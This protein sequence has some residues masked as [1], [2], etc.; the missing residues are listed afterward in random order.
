MATISR[1]TATFAWLTAAVVVLAAAQRPTPA[2]SGVV[3]DIAGRPI[4]AIEIQV[5]TPTGATLKIL[6]AADGSYEI[7]IKTPGQYDI[8]MERA[9]FKNQRA[10]RFVDG[11]SRVQHDMLLSIGSISQ[12]LTITGNKPAGDSAPA[13][14]IPPP[15]PLTRDP[16]PLSPKPCEFTAGGSDIVEPRKVADVRPIYPLDLL[17]DGVS[18]TVVLKGLVTKQGT[19]ADIKVLQEAHEKLAAAASA[20]VAQWQF[21]PTRLNCLPVEVELNVTVNF[22][23]GR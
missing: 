22:T 1:S 20:A 2:I 13:V 12:E 5:V 17:A 7:P 14:P 21:T 3:R 4:H 11:R 10:L 16:A 9:G 23:T 18:G 19:V 15:P 8:R 6:T